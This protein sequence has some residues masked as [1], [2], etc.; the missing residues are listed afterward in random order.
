MDPVGLVAGRQQKNYFAP[1]ASIAVLR[2][3]LGT[4]MRIGQPVC[5][6]FCREPIFSG[7]VVLLKSV[8]DYITGC[9]ALTV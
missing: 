9:Y 3:K 2:E 6:G 7:A 8:D 1:T 5:C 4:D